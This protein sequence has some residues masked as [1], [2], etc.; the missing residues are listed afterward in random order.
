MYD[1]M[2][3][4]AMRCRSAQSRF[5]EERRKA[6]EVSP[7]GLIVI[8]CGRDD[9]YLKKYLKDGCTYIKLEKED[10]DRGE[11]C[12]RILHTVGKTVKQLNP[13]S[14]C[15]GII[16]KQSRLTKLM[17]RGFFPL[18]PYESTDSCDDVPGVFY[19]LIDLT[20]PVNVVSMALS[21]VDKVLFKISDFVSCIDQDSFTLVPEASHSNYLLK[22]LKIELID[23]VERMNVVL[24]RLQMCTVLETISKIARLKLALPVRSPAWRYVKTYE[25]IRSTKYQSS[26]FQ[27]SYPCLVKPQIGCGPS[28]AHQMALVLQPEGFDEIEIPSP[29]V[30]QEYVNHS[31]MVW[32]VYVAGEQ[33][34]YEQRV[35]MPD[36]DMV[37]GQELPSC[38]E[39]DS[40]KSLPTCLPW[41]RPGNRK[42]SNPDFQ[43]IMNQNF[44]QQ[45]ARVVREEVGLQVLGFDVVFDRKAGEAVIIDINYFPSFG[46]LKEAPKAFQKF[47]INTFKNDLL[48]SS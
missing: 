29:G 21:Y 30:I 27:I 38:V 25:D 12:G 37:T 48:T 46:S 10:F 18:N 26:G 1:A 20:E 9:K 6:G 11:A 7:E 17:S 31:S 33:V 22:Q 47:V 3:Y 41:M 40:L 5:V 14:H 8:C 34:L 2:H 19:C 24:D 13:D 45:L 35:S 39:F 15:V 43:G 32:K 23:P 36:I 16:A 44:L 4:V 42:I 28:E